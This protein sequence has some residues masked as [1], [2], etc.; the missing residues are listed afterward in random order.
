MATSKATAQWNG[1][2][3]QGSGTMKP[4]HGPEVAFSAATRFA[5]ETGSNPEELIGAAF[6]GCFSMAL[7]VALEQAGAPP[8]TI[9]TSATV[10]VDR[11][12]AAG[13]SDG[14]APFEIHDIAL[15]TEVDAPGLDAARLQELVAATK[16]GC[17]VGKALASVGN[18]SVEAKLVAG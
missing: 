18:I 1:T 12:G 6:A 8:K 11:G 9:R 7:S 13:S 2:I 15:S 3:K 10:K 14:K 16:K 5:G 17:P 4:A